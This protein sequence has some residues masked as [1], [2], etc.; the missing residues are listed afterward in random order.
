MT[1]QWLLSQGFDEA[2]ANAAMSNPDILAS[3]LKRLEGGDQ[4]KVFGTPIW[5]TVE[6][7]GETGLGSFDENGKFHLIDTPGFK[8]ERG[9]RTVETE[10]EIL[11]LNTSDGSIIAR[12]PKDIGGKIVEEERGKAK[13]LLE[14]MKSKMPGLEKTVAELKELAKKATYTTGGQLWDEVRKQTGREP[15]EAAV[16]ATEYIKMVDTTMI[17]LLRDMLGPQ[18]TAT[19]NQMVRG[20]MGDATMHPT[21]KQAVLDNFVRG[22]IREIEA[23]A[24]QAGEAPEKT[25]NPATGKIE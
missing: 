8:P 12:T 9:I 16:A 22:K 20:I 6:E 21:E 3:L 1:Q 13:A 23:T 19:E 17:P 15:R 5:G 4:A 14:S 2:T 25:Y 24:A 11:T 10:T 18:F 7:T